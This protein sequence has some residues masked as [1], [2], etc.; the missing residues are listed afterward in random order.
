MEEQQGPGHISL[1]DR[2]WSD[3]PRK[4]RPFFSL[5]VGRRSPDMVRG[6]LL[7]PGA[8]HASVLPRLRCVGSPTHFNCRCNSCAFFN[9][10]P[11]RSLLK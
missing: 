9:A 3:R 7:N 5:G 4:S 10:F 1:V 11:S 6:Q 2:Y 8:Y